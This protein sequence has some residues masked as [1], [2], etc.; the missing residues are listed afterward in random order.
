M[1]GKAHTFMHILRG[2][3][4]A[5]SLGV[6]NTSIL[7][8]YIYIYIYIYKEQDLNKEVYLKTKSIYNNFI[9]SNQVRHG[10]DRAHR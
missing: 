10:C 5:E 8:I 9:K 4:A 7:Y 3:G 6:I 1:L 2:G